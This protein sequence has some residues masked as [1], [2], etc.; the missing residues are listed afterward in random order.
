MPICKTNT[1]NAEY[2]N[3]IYNHLKIN[4][5]NT[6]I[7]TSQLNL[8]FENFCF[9][10]DN[11]MNVNKCW[12]TVKTCRNKF[13]CDFCG[14]KNH[15]SRDCNYE[16]SFGPIYRLAIGKWA[17]MYISQFD[18]PR[19]NTRKLVELND[20]SPSLD[21]VCKNCGQKI[22][23][24][25]KCLSIKDLPKDIFLPH[26]NFSK[27]EKRVKENLDLIIV[28]YGVDR[29]SKTFFVRKVL[30]IPNK[31]LINESKIKVKQNENSFSSQICIPDINI[32]R[33]LTLK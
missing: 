15:N 12:S 19:C 27:Y 16:H 21:I 8:F 4:L 17:E 33:Q 30:Y 5:K 20:N 11:N 25:S 29:K 31:E 18:C 9:A 6:D 28:I 26:G 3:K 7:T 13:M 24:K 23:V 14:E 10:F 2:I 1:D 32:F 22:E